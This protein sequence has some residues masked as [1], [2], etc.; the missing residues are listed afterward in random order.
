MN[1]NPQKIIEYAIYSANKRTINHILTIIFIGM[2]MSSV[3]NL[4]VNYFSSK[5]STDG[6]DRSGLKLHIDDLTG[7]HYLSTI[8]GSL[9]PRYTKNQIHYG[10]K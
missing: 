1:N 7:C 8:K 6:A 4:A 10:C 9:F 5:D 3:V 2:I